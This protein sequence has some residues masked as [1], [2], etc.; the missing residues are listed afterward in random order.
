MKTINAF[1][2]GFGAAVALDHWGD[3]V[4]ATPLFVLALGILGIIN[5]MRNILFARP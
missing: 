1:A 5:L 2:L 4:Q 3:L